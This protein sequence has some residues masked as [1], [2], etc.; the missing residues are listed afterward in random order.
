MGVR[1][2]VPGLFSESMSQGR[3]RL[4]SCE[5]V[6]KATNPI[7]GGGSLRRATNFQG[8]GGSEGLAAAAVVVKGQERRSRRRE[9]ARPGSQGTGVRRRARVTG[10]HCSVVRSHPD[11]RVAWSSGSLRR[12][13]HGPASS[14]GRS[15]GGFED[16][17]VWEEIPQ[18]GRTRTRTVLQEGNGRRSGFARVGGT[19]SRRDQSF[20]AGE[21][22]L[23]G[24]SAMR[25]PVRPGSGSFG[26][27]GKGAHSR[28][29]KRATAPKGVGVPETAGDKA[30][31]GSS[32]GFGG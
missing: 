8:L 25:S 13:A 23:C 22:G 17:E 12:H 11:P 24:G 21:A 1:R 5:V 29:G 3:G 10:F 28:R 2:R 31:L 26:G 16:S 20:E 30:S 19:D 7:G 14:R 4:R 15:L 18:R 32:R 6:E 9:A 27:C